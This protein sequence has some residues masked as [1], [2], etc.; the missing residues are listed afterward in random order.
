MADLLASDEK[1]L[2]PQLKDSVYMSDVLIDKKGEGYWIIGEMR[3]DTQFILPDY[4]KDVFDKIC[5]LMD[6]EHTITEIAWEVGIPESEVE[7]I[8]GMLIGKGMIHGYEDAEIK[9]FNEVDNFSIKL[10]NYYFKDIKDKEKSKSIGK[11]ISKVGLCIFIVSLIMFFVLNIENGFS[12]FNNFELEEWLSYGN[13][14]ASDWL[15]YLLINFGMVFMFIF[16]ELGHV[17]VGIRYGLQPRNVSFVL[18]F[19]F[20]P[21]FYVKNKNIYSLK[22]NQSIAV[23]SAGFYMN[24]ILAFILFNI[25]LVTDNELFRILSL[26]NI[27]IILYNIWPFSMS[28][29]YFILTILFRYPN[30]RYKF[31]QFLSKP[32]ILMK[33]T[34]LE[35]VY[36]LVSLILL[37]VSMAIEIIWILSLLSLSSNLRNILLVLIIFVY[38]IALHFLEKRKFKNLATEP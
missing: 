25:F 19:G 29:G 9:R 30:L 6:G 31:H 10:I 27:R 16:H 33:Y 5:N 38:F 23:L 35:V 20:M 2:M 17:V 8:M 21:M 15:G 7:K 22:R 11:I 13:D 34:S 28:D 12:A 1:N 37:V 32:A 14:N 36:S 26:S 4:Q 18:H 3:K 24:L